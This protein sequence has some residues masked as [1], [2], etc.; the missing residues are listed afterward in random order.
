MFLTVVSV[1]LRGIF[2]NNL[3][4]PAQ[5]V[6]QTVAP[7]LRVFLLSLEHLLMFP[8][9]LVTIVRQFGNRLPLCMQGYPISFISYVRVPFIPYH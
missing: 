1:C 9:T 2:M 5:P 7:P 4:Y 8:V 6:P 3:H